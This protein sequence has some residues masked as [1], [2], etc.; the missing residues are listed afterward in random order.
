MKLCDTGQQDLEGSA[1]GAPTNLDT[2]KH[3]VGQTRLDVEVVLRCRSRLP[4]ARQVRHNPGCLFMT[5]PS[6]PSPRRARRRQRRPLCPAWCP[7]LRI[8]RDHKAH[9][10]CFDTIAPGAVL[11]LRLT[12]DRGAQ[13][14]DRIRIIEVILAH[15]AASMVAH[16]EDPLLEKPTEISSGFRRPQRHFHK[17]SVVDLLSSHG[18]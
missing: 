6:K 15:L 1:L 17:I 12:H 4:L 10:S 11:P 18:L 14:V 16:Y 5:E 3:D 8:E 2:D 9:A 13:D 7:G